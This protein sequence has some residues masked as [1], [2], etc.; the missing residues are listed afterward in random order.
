MW[1]IVCGG[2]SLSAFTHVFA[3]YWLIAAPLGIVATIVVCAREDQRTGVQ[4][5]PRPYWW[6]GGA[7]T[8][9]N[10]ASSALLPG[11]TVVVVIWVVFGFG[12]VAFAWLDHQPTIAALFAA[13]AIAIGLSGPIVPDTL[14]LYVVAGLV[15]AATMVGVAVG[16]R[17]MGTAR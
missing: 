15:Y 4:R 16:I 9:I 2:A 1:A 10:F 11:R 6:V 14:T 17:S 3:W 13:L 5:D 7:I 12:F 8:V